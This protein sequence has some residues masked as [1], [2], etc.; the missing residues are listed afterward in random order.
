MKTNLFMTK[1][2]T[3]YTENIF[4]LRKMTLK[5]FP[6]VFSYM[7]THNYVPRNVCSGFHATMFEDRFMLSK[8][9]KYEI[10]QHLQYG[11][12]LLYPVYLLSDRELSCANEICNICPIGISYKSLHILPCSVTSMYS[13]VRIPVLDVFHIH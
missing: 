12:T 13:S 8:M 4:K 2:I 6:H 1:L 7:Y 10:N 9:L 5:H 11:T 3:K